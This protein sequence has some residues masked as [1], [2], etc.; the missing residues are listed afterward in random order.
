MKR[1]CLLVSVAIALGFSY[2]HAAK[3]DI[4]M[5]MIYFPLARLDYTYSPNAGYEL[6]DNL[7]WQPEVT[8]NLGHGFRIGAIASIYKR[9]FNYNS[10]TRKNVSL[11]GIGIIG[12]YAYS[13]TEAG[14]TFLTLG[15]ETGYAMLHERSF[16]VS[17]SGSAWMA[18]YV[19]MKYIIYRG[20]SVEIDYRLSRLEFDIKKTPERKYKFNG[21]SLKLTLGYEFN[22]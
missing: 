6:V 21:N 1:I 7:F 15:A 12:N 10:V 9:G 2:I 17:T 20:A 4:G 8:Y 3:V 22:I 18:G 16:G 13:F 11:T 19:G 14:H 5:S